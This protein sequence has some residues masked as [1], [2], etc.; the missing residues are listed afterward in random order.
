MAKVT[1]G[2]GGSGSLSVNI[3]DMPGKAGEFARSA[4][5]LEDTLQAVTTSINNLRDEWSGTGSD[6]FNNV[7]I[8]WQKDADAIRQTLE[9]V[10]TSVKQAGIQ[11]GELE[12]A[13]KQ[14]F[15]PLT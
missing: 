14:G 6:S 3:A 9:D 4:Q 7:M 8:R 2:G 5:A 10:S 13:I 11:Y 12:Q 1:S 15:T